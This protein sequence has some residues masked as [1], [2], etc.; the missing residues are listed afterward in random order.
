M[1]RTINKIFSNITGEE[2]K[3]KREISRKIPLSQLYN[4]HNKCQI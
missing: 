4:Y 2:E 1:V 3:I